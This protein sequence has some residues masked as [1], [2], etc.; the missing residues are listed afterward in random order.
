MIF[1]TEEAQSLILPAIDEHKNNQIIPDKKKLK[2]IVN[3]TQNIAFSE[4]VPNRTTKKENELTR[5][6]VI[7]ERLTR[8]QRVREDKPRSL[9]N[10]VITRFYR[11]PEVIV[12][13]KNYDQKVDMW[14]LG[15]MFAE[16]LWCY[17]E[18]MS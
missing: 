17:E 6:K 10:H 7:S 9:S 14:S 5:R 15:C 2:K 16:L 4:H 18:K 3:K 8:D 11:P 12:L 13:E 1:S